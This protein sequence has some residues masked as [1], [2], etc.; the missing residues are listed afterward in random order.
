VDHCIKIRFDKLQPGPGFLPVYHFCFE[1]QDDIRL[2]EIKSEVKRVAIMNGYAIPNLDQRTFK[3][4]VQKVYF[5][6]FAIRFDK[7]VLDKCDAAESSLVVHLF[8]SLP[9]YG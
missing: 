2:A 3:G 1:L 5:N 9:C 6:R 8:P 4:N 7:A